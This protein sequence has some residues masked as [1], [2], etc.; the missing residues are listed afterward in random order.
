M[1]DSGGR[2]SSPQ[3]VRME[4]ARHHCTNHRIRGGAGV[5]DRNE[6]ASFARYYESQVR[7]QLLSVRTVSNLRYHE[8]AG[9]SRGES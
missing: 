2:E 8:S 4:K 6:L 1:P 7:E 3:Q 5:R 9:W